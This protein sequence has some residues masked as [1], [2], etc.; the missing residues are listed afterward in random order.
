MSQ[1]EQTS[2]APELVA[3]PGQTVDPKA[4]EVTAEVKEAVQQTINAKFD[5]NVSPT[6][7]K[8]TFKTA[9]IKDD[10][11]KPTGEKH[12]RPA[13][14]VILPL[15]NLSGIKSIL[16]SGD[17]KSQQLLL[18]AVQAIQFSQAKDLVDS[19]VNI[20][21]ETFPLDQVSWAHIANLPKAE[22]SGSAIAKE[23]WEAFG[24][25][26]IAAMQR[27][28]GKTPDQAKKAAAIL[29][30]KLNPAKTNKPVLLNLQGQL[31]IFID[32][33]EE[34]ADFLPCVEYLTKRV[35]TLLKAEEPDLLSAL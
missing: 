17:E 11:G 5:V 21:A 19:D 1:P 2:T 23:T 15:I 12:K 10:E 27:V 18:E 28:A 30:A 24:T 32:Q 34:A 29:V 9:D 16:E 3:T 33:A 4:L 20:T 7:A 35:E 14:T 13:V 6:E 25:A 31:G 8:F 22:R 26:W